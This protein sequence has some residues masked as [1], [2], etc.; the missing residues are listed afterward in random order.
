MQYYWRSQGDFSCFPLAH[1]R[2]HGYAEYMTGWFAPAICK[3]GK[4]I[5]THSFSFFGQILLED[6][7]IDNAAVDLKLNLFP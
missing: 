7:D 2:T 4:S 5:P 3:Q 6:D 1:A